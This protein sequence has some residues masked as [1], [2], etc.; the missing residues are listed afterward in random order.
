MMQFMARSFEVFVLLALLLARATEVKIMN[1]NFGPRLER[2]AMR[3]PEKDS[4]ITIVHG[5]IR[6]G[7]TYSLHTKILYCCLYPVAGRKVLTG[8]SKQSIFNNVLNDLFNMVGSSNYG[9]NRHTGE[10]RLCNSQWLVIGAKDEGSERYIRGLTVGV[11]VCDELVVQPPSFV[12]M[13]LNRMSP[14][15]ARFY[16]TTNP[17]TPFHYVKTDLLDN[18]KLRDSGQLRSIHVTLE[19]NPNLPQQYKDNLRRLYHGV[20][21]RRY[22]LGQWVIAEGAIYGDSWS[23]DLL[24][25]SREEPE[26][27]RCQGGHQQR[28]I[29]VDYGTSNPMVFLDIYDDGQIFWVVGEYYWD[30][31][32]EARQKTDAEYADD[33]FHF[34]GPQADA[35][36]I[37]DPSAASFKAE[38]TKRGIWHGDADVDVNQGIRKVSMVLNQ[39]LVRFCR[40]TVSKTIQ[41]M[42]TYAWD[43]RAAQRGEEKPLKIHDHGPDAFRYFVQ[44][45]VSYWRLGCG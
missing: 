27:L 20:Y 2:F 10:L 12:K 13:L 3:P 40:Q 33:L 5:A 45:E 38:L 31:V 32:A 34:I 11:A 16:A 26:D 8:A 30:S 28:F 22:V 24:Y 1:F 43:P 44:T 18:I 29:A 36:V 17:D 14:E 19:D 4:P 25:D 37:V 6:S 42:Q 7:K 21:Y 23:D 41:E 39:R 15:G 9:Y 35:K